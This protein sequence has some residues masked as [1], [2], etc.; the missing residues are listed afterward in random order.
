MKSSS[1]G[2]NLIWP[3]VREKA[4][5]ARSNA[6]CSPVRMR[7][8]SVAQITASSGRKWKNGSTLSCKVLFPM[9]GTMTAR[10]ILLMLS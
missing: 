6:T 9:F 4:C 7:S 5:S 3:E 2:V 10:V 1:G 8:T